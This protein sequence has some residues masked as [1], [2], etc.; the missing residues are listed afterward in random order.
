MNG[1]QTILMVDDSEDDLMLMRTAF[2][3]AEWESPLQSVGN[4]EDAMAYLIGKGPYS[5]RR[6][7]PLPII[8]LL[9]LNMPKMDGFEVLSWVRSQPGLKRLAI[10]ILSA[11]TRT[12][13]VVSAFDLGATSYLVKPSGLDELTGMLDCL[14]QWIRINQ[15]P[16]LIDSI[17]K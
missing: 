10:M 3:M 17:R 13:D 14:R 8:M 7:F 5:D 12:D 11:S 9:D 4:G 2:E 1:Q 16:P 15:F 6:K